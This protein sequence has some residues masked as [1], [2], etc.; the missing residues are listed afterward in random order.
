MI[1]EE[2]ARIF[3]SA[4]FIAELGMELVEIGEGCCTTQLPVAR[5]HLQQDGF[6][7]A[8]VQATMA[9]HSAGAA[10]AT[11]IGP[12]QIVLTSEFKIHLLRA[13]RGQRMVCR[14]EVLKPGRMISVVESE[15]FT[16][17]GGVERLV[18]KA[19]VSIA[20]VEARIRT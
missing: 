11:L 20:V 14:S 15:V 16:I 5:R 12:G 13:A 18:A 6:V 2:I 10:A 7:H 19:M 4:P 1:D 3:K 17:D 9:D 8:G